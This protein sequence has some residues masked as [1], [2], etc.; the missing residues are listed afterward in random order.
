MIATPIK[1]FDV[2]TINTS[3]RKGPMKYILPISVFGILLLH[4]TDAIPLDGV[5]GSIVIGLALLVAAP[6]VGVHEAWTMKRNVL[7]WIANI[8]VSLVGAFFFAP[9]G[10]MIIVLVISPFM[11]GGGS[12]ADA[13]GLVMYVALAGMMVIT[14]LGA[15][16]SLWIV[17]R[18]R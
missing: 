2:D 8:I 15:W 11:D 7:G 4:S 16:G 3:A 5:G 14:L 13:G 10:G 6:A 1:T 12:I 9:V 17:N 18:W